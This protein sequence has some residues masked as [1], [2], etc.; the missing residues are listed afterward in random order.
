MW[1]TMESA[2]KDGQPILLI[3]AIN[4]QGAKIEPVVGYWSAHVKA[5]KFHP[6]EVETGD[7]LVPDRWHNLPVWN[8][9]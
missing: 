9:G 5:W 6:S 2:P 8:G 3:A 4:R 1:K 7:D